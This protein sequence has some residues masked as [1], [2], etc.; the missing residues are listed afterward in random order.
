MAKVVSGVVLG[1]WWQAGRYLGLGATTPQARRVQRAAFPGGERT[2]SRLP[3]AKRSF[4]KS[5]EATTAPGN[6]G[7]ANSV[8]YT[9]TQERPDHRTGYALDDGEAAPPEGSMRIAQ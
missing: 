3:W 9:A 6:G 5:I 4:Q 2:R 8:F 1:R 7:E